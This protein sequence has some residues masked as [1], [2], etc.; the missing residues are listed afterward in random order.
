MLALRRWVERGGKLWAMLDR[1]EP[2]SL[3]P[4][5]GDALDFQVVDRVR[6]ASVRLE[7]PKVGQTFPEKLDEHIHE[8]PVEFVRVLLPPQERVRHT[9]GGWPSWF[10][11]KI[12]RGEVIF[13]A[14]GARGWTRARGP[15]DKSSPYPNY[16]SLPVGLPGFE[17]VALELHPEEDH[18]PF[19]GE[20]FGPPLTEEIGYSVVGRTTVGLVFGAFVLAA[21]G[22]GIALRKSSRRELLGWV[23]PAA[24]LGAAG[25]FVALGEWSRRAVPPTV[26]VAQIV[27]PIAGIR[28]ASV[29]GMVVVYRPDAGP[30]QVGASQGGLFELDMAGLEGQT[31][32]MIQTDLTSWHWENLSLPA[33]VRSAPFHYT[34]SLAEPITAVA[35]FGPESLEG[36]LTAGPFQDPGD[37][38]LCTPTG[39]NLALRMQADGSFRTGSEDILPAGQFLAGAVLTDRQQR[40]Q[41][42]YRQFLRKP[43]V[44]PL[45]GRNLLLAWANPIDMHFNLAAQARHVG[46]ALLVVP[47]QLERSPPGTRVTI[48]GPLLAYRRVLVPYGHLQVGTLTRPVLESNQE[49]TQHIRF[50]LPAEVLPLQVERARLTAKVSAPTRQVTISARPDGKPVELLR[51]DSPLDPL[52]IDI[53]QGSTSRLDEGGGLNFEVRVSESTREEAAGKGG[54]GEREKWVIEYLELEVTGQTGKKEG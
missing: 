3:A 54:F 24:A 30:A 51:V 10:S 14:L 11:R 53:P 34:A 26:A 52:R 50:Q 16:P 42:L 38:L 29:N 32:R 27:D 1:I 25:T 23:G 33:G 39:R 36:R 4:L 13:T 15:K 12:G 43:D 35:H 17:W 28:E 45:E 40:R 31:R 46:S 48:P 20:F 44:G 22:L 49:T 21:A 6:L 47:I 37:A 5:L 19:R 2:E 9:I 18:N 41:G 8:R 7:A